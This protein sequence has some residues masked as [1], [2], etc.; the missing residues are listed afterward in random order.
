[1]IR[2][3]VSIGLVYHVAYNAD[4]SIED[5]LARIQQWL[6]PPDPLLNLRKSQTAIYGDRQMVP[7]GLSV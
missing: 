1:L 6:E 5:M 2:A 7:A 3:I 4:H